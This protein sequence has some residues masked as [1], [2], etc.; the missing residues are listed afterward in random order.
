M[1]NS[2]VMIWAGNVAHVGR[3]SVHTVLVGKPEGKKLLGRPK[4]RWKDNIKM[5]FQ[6]V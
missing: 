4:R 6:E 5:D 3:R 2:K 1:I